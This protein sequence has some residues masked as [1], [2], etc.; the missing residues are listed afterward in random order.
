M[1]E[2]YSSIVIIGA[3]LNLILLMHGDNSLTIENNTHILKIN[4]IIQLELFGP[5]NKNHCS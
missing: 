2:Q 4:I 1:E 3:L 5:F